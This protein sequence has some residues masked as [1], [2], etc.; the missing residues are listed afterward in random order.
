MDEKII[1]EVLEKFGQVV[2]VVGLFEIRNEGKPSY[3]VDIQEKQVKVS[4]CF[5]LGVKPE[6]VWH[7]AELRALVIKEAVFKV[8]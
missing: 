1:F 7:E 8:L 3:V 6:E 2:K 4:P 5:G